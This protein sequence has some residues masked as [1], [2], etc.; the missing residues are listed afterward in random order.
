MARDEKQRAL[1]VIGVEDVNKKLDV[2]VNV[3]LKPVEQ[4]LDE[5]R[6]TLDSQIKRNNQLK[7][8]MEGGN[9]FLFTR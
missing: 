4:Q 5:V 9:K 7:V 2:E 6:S 3:A 8:N 1:R